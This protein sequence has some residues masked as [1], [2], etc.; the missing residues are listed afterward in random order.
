MSSRATTERG[1]FVGSGRTVAHYDL[2]RA[3]KCLYVIGRGTL[4]GKSR[5]FKAG[6]CDYRSR[7]TVDLRIEGRADAQT[8]SAF[9]PV[10]NGIVSVRAAPQRPRD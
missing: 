4:V 7:G 1:E 10:I 5:R 2:N 6:A 9:G 8:L 3:A